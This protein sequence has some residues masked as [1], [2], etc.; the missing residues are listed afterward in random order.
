MLKI[1]H[2]IPLEEYISYYSTF[3]TFCLAICT[4][5]KAA[6]AFSTNSAAAYQSLFSFFIT[7]SAAFSVRYT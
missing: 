5:Q 1:C 4:L 2:K 6:D 7:V 3:L